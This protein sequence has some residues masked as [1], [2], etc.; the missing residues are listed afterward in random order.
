G[1]GPD[2]QFFV[3]ALVEEVIHGQS[4]MM[5]H[6]EQSDVDEIRS[7]THNLADRVGVATDRYNSGLGRLAGMEFL[8]PSEHD[9]GK[10]S[11]ANASYDEVVERSRKGPSLFFKN[12]ESR[13]LRALFWGWFSNTLDA[14]NLDSTRIWD[15]RNCAFVEDGGELDQSRFAIWQKL[16][17]SNQLRIGID[18]RTEVGGSEGRVTRC[19]LLDMNFDSSV[20][21][22][23]P[24]TREKAI[25]VHGSTNVGSTDALQGLFLR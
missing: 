3:E 17:A 6:F 11:P 9:S 1:A 8:R 19:V 10:H 15:G 14:P 7:L 16:R 24:V 18:C 23:F 25:S 4:T 13:D 12:V 2:D 20:I 22:A 5:E 21:H